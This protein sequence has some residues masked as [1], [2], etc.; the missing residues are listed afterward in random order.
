VHARVEAPERAD[1]LLVLPAHLLGV[2]LRWGKGRGERRRR[3]SGDD[4]RRLVC[5]NA[6]AGRG[7]TRAGDEKAAKRRGRDRRRGM[8]RTL[9]STR[10]CRSQTACDAR[11][12]GRRRDTD[13]AP[14]R[15]RVDAPTN[16]C[17]ADE[18]VRP[19]DHKNAV[20]KACILAARQNLGKYPYDEAS[21]GKFPRR[22][23][24]CR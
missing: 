17:P 20:H 8:V 11:C 10:P 23:E 15:R 12:G 4:P 18:R 9:M 5:L 24:S 7:G 14:R 2:S 22:F 19:T 6:R 3:V 21:T 16:I 13:R 1:V